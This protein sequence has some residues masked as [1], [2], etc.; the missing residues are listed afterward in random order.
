M[1]EKI[2]FKNILK[3]N[4]RIGALKD[5]DAL[6]E[7]ILYE[8]R[9]FTNADA[10]TIYLV[11]NGKLS[12]E[13]VQNDSLFKK[14]AKNKFL[15]KS[16]MIEINDKSIAGYVALTGRPLN[17]V[18]AYEIPK[19]Y[20]F[21]FNKKFDQE[22]SYRT[23]SILTY[24]LKTHEEQLIGI[25]QL[26][27][28]KENNE[29]VTFKEDDLLLVRYFATIAAT[30]IERALIT[31]EMILRMINMAELRDPKETGAHVN[32]VGAYSVE[33]YKEWAEKNNITNREI[34]KTEDNLRIAAMLH[35]IGK[36]AISDVILKKPGKLNEE[37][38]NIMKLHTITGARLFKNKTSDMDRVGF[39]V[40]LNHHERWDGKGYPGFIDDVFDEKVELKTGKKGEEIPLF[41]RIVAVADVYDALVSKRAYKEAWSDEEAIKEME[42]QKGKQFD[43]ELVDAFL[44]IY[45]VIKAIREKFRE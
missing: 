3:L 45:D 28:K 16:Q 44:S 37:E 38:Y 31:R 39:E 34:K 29:S 20:P 33:L 40:A 9:K 7:F 23:K 19:E 22:T 26:I 25:L 13:Y 36:V 11:K 18:D 32:R 10:G 15:Y 30:S 41:G 43:P 5:I 1:V 14:E 27:N 8:A 6:L 35:D 12:F 42:F 17:I 24:P 21:C 2:D 4:E